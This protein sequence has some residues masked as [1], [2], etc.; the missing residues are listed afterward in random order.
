MTPDFQLSLDT[1]KDR[2]NAVP[3][4][5]LRSFGMNIK[6]V[7]D[8]TFPVLAGAGFSIRTELSESHGKITT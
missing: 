3:K 5:G 7:G 6:T 4:L 1:T 8:Y 2:I